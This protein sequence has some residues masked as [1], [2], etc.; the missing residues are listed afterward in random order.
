ML[1]M[2]LSEGSE[3]ILLGLIKQMIQDNPVLLQNIVEP[4]VNEIISDSNV[5]DKTKEHIADSVQNYFDENPL[6][7]LITSKFEECIVDA[8]TEHYGTEY[9]SR[10]VNDWI[11]EQGLDPEDSMMEAAKALIDENCSLDDLVHDAITNAVEEHG[12]IEDAIRDKVEDSVSDTMR[13]DIDVESIAEEVIKDNIDEYISE[14]TKREI[15]R[16]TIDRM[17]SGEIHDEMLSC[18]LDEIRRLTGPIV[19]QTVPNMIKEQNEGI[20]E[21]TT[22]TIECKS[23]KADIIK[24][25][26]SNCMQDSLIKTE[27][28][29]DDDRNNT[30]S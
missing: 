21:W 23:D 20:A 19:A 13:N 18:M 28:E 12:S 9:V 24:S 3:S 4:C 11:G 10:M 1:E 22:I 30:G 15:Q 8:F 2:K 14:E 27:I 6:G 7:E 17:N 16:Q 25:F 29:K 5:S 26:I